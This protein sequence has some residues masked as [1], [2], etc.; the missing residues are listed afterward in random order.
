MRKQKKVLILVG[1]VIVVAVILLGGFFAYQ[2]YVINKQP[3]VNQ[4]PQTQNQTNQTPQAQGQTSQT[5]QTN[6]IYQTP[7]TQNQTNQT[8]QAQGQTSQT[9][10]WQTYS[11]YGISFK[12]PAEMGNPIVIKLAAGASIGFGNSVDFMVGSYYDPDLKRN[13]TFDEMINSAMTSSDAAQ[14]ARKNTTLDGKNGVELDYTSKTT[15][16]GVTE[17]FIPIDKNGNMLIAIEYNRAISNSNGV[18]L[19][20]ILPTLTFTPA[21]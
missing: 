6:Q 2:Y 7:Q 17:I 13:I 8:P 3:A 10:G 9:A 19:N 20:E 21:E 1:I 15:G 4:T 12:Y 14:V 11:G 18:S 5:P 16:S